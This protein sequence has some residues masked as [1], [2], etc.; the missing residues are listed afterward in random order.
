MTDGLLL[1]IFTIHNKCLKISSTWINVH[2][3]TSEY[4]LSHPS[5]V[6]WEI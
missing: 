6:L 2:M 1:F 5:E 4:E 3:D